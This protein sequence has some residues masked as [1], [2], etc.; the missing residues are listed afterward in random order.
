MT[1]YSLS[2]HAAD[3]LQQRGI[4]PI[5]IDLLERF[6]ASERSNGA[7]K[8]FFDKKAKKNLQHHFGGAGSLRVLEPWL[9]AYAV[10]A[11]D[12]VV[13]TAGRRRKRI[14]RQ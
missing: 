13:I 9:D 12:G 14:V 4:P 11:D 5:V 7:E 6:G 8:I 3:R 2:R 10:I 1:N